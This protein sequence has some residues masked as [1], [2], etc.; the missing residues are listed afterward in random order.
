MREL[1]ARPSAVRQKRNKTFEYPPEA[2][3]S[4]KGFFASGVF[5]F[6][7]VGVIRP[8]LP[9][10]RRRLRPVGWLRFGSRGSAILL[11]SR[12]FSVATHAQA[13]PICHVVSGTTF[14]HWY[15]VVCVCFSLVATHA[16]AG[17]AGP[18]GPC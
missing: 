10:R 6:G 15:D 12:L 7:K 3:A 16:T 8:T 13:L 11:G 1:F 17:P 18:C 2:G 4:K 14:A 9:S 5:L